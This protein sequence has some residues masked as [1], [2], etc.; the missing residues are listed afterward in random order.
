[1]L[2]TRA[3]GVSSAG[4]F[5]AFFF[6]LGAMRNGQL[7][8]QRTPEVA[9]GD[10]RSKP[11][12]AERFWHGTCLTVAVRPAWV[13]IG[14][15]FALA[16]FAA[17]PAAACTCNATAHAAV[18]E[19]FPSDAA[20]WVLTNRPDATRLES[21]EGEPIG[22]SVA[23]SLPGGG[24]CG[25]ALSALLPSAPFSADRYLLRPA[26][27]TSGGVLYEGRS[28]VLVEPALQSASTTVELVVEIE[29]F[30]VEPS[31]FGSCA[32]PILLPDRTTSSM[33]GVRVTSSEPAVFAVTSTLND[34]LAG[35]LT[36]W[37]L[38]IDDEQRTPRDS[39]IF[40]DAW[41]DGASDCVEIATYDLR[42]EQVQS[43][44]YCLAIGD[45]ETRSQVVELRV[46]TPAAPPL[47]AAGGC[48]VARGAR[49]ASSWTLAA[50]ALLAALRRRRLI[51]LLPGLLVAGC[52]GAADPA[53][54]RAPFIAPPDELVCDP[55]FGACSSDRFCDDLGRADNCGQCGTDCGHL[56]CVDGACQ[57]EQPEVL[58]ESQ[59]RL[60]G[61]ASNGHDLA[62]LSSDGDVTGLVDGQPTTL[63]RALEFSWE[64][65]MNDAF[66][67]FQSY[68]AH[69]R[70]VSLDGKERSDFSIDNGPVRSLV[71]SGAGVYWLADDPEQSAQDLLFLSEGSSSP[72]VLRHARMLP[73]ARDGER[74]CTA[75]RDFDSTLECWTKDTRE[76]WPIPP[77]DGMALLAVSGGAAFSC[78]VAGLQ[79]IEL[80]SG[81]AL[82]PITEYCG[83]VGA[84]AGAVAMVDAHLNI[85]TLDAAA[86]QP[87]LTAVGAT[88]SF[89]AEDLLV[90]GQRVC[91][92]EDQRV[93]C[94]RVAL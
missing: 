43:G 24:L 6:V 35:K 47:V 7:G 74:V 11:D 51:A 32:D 88:P 56:A 86:R 15:L 2:H 59:A 61:L 21:P 39:I 79:R 91:W 13:T 78:S 60:C 27:A 8:W 71:A 22:F 75:V 25:K 80:T 66:V 44:E 87:T 18:P 73:L 23:A 85:L 29:R 5:S 20:L 93:L 33:L 31:T 58:F 50:L 40:H 37:Q 36:N 57:G 53:D 76:S 64:L 48:S 63:G 65:A 83:Q 69:L 9:R 81:A 17:R 30:A 3:N 92:L 28:A 72:I 52:D 89:Y 62:L 4:V 34:P 45:L 54:E 1:M 16:V 38:T 55:G 90:Q 26:S 82:S 70:R 10:R 84:G 42:G 68:A 67:F 19:P 14:G 41:V 77:L 49:R 12:E 46:A 94:T